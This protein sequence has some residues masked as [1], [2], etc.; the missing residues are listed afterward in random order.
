MCNI[1]NRR[2][3][4]LIENPVN[5]RIVERSLEL[6]EFLLQTR[7]FILAKCFMT[8]RNAIKPSICVDKLST[9]EY[10]YNEI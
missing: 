8:V 4:I 5:I 9:S 6:I 2:E 10:S 3:F 7:E 1:V